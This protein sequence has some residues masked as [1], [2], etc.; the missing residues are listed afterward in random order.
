MRRAGFRSCLAL[1]VPAY[2]RPFVGCMLFSRRPNQ[3]SEHTMDLVMLFAL[4]AGTTF[5][6]AALYDDSRQ[7]VD[8]LHAALATRYLIG[9]AKGVLMRRYSC[10][11]DEAFHLLRRLSQHHNVKIRHL[12]AEL[13]D[14]QQ[15]GTL[16]ELLGRWFASGEEH[17]D[18]ATA[19]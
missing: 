16:E 13:V 5:D 3:F 15:D 12:A 18:F 10:S 2:R 8:Q 17:Q 19:T 1:P 14:A 4:H 11:S 6:N 7:L 9:Q